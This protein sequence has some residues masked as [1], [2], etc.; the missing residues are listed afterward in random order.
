LEQLQRRVVVQPQICLGAQGLDVDS[1][2]G[3]MAQD[4]IKVTAGLSIYE[5]MMLLAIS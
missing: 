4:E 3:H 2:P 1:R 5:G